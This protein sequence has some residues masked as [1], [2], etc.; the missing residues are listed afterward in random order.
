MKFKNNNNILKIINK[1][2]YKYIQYLNIYYNF[3]Y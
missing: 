1:T 3:I 2:I